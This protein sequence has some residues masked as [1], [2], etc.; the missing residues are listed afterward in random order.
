MKKS[1][2]FISLSL[3]IFCVGIMAVGVYAA[4]ASKKTFNVGGAIKIPANLIDVTVHG[5][6]GDADINNDGVI[7][8][9]TDAILKFNSALGDSTWILGEDDLLFDCESVTSE[10]LIPTKTLTIS[11]VNNC[12]LSLDVGLLADQSNEIPDV[13]GFIS[14][15][16]VGNGVTGGEI[17]SVSATVG[18][19]LVFKIVLSINKL[20]D[21]NLEYIFSYLLNIEQKD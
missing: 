3:L 12:E 6:L 5:Y 8:N 1:K 15:D 7:D 19:T 10:E 13:D 14:M 2:I 4:S 18:S 9:D 21:N 16:I 20:S 17:N 11:I